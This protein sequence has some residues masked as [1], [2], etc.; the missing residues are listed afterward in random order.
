M[1]TGLGL[2]SSIWDGKLIILCEIALALLCSLG[3]GSCWS[4]SVMLTERAEV[5][6]L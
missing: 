6:E 3:H 4:S 5:L 1:L 2:Q